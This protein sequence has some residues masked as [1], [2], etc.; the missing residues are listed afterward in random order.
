[1][2]ALTDVC[3]VEDDERFVLLER[4]ARAG[5]AFDCEQCGPHWRNAALSGHARD[6]E[7]HGFGLG[8]G[9]LVLARDDGPGN[10]GSGLSLPRSDL[11]YSFLATSWMVRK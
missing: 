11:L 5:D 10:V 3:S 2:R 7:R 6:N 1:M 4:D 8:F 9:R